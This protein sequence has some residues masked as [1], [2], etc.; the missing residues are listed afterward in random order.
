MR[1]GHSGGTRVAQPVKELIDR[2]ET[3]RRLGDGVVNGPYLGENLE[4]Y[5]PLE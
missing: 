4:K 1:L 3:L 5:L 2:A